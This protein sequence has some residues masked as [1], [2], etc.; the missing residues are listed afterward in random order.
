MLY[1]K[2]KNS[3]KKVKLSK[4]KKNIDEIKDEEDFN[5]LF[6]MD[7]DLYS[8]LD[9]YYDEILNKKVL[10]WATSEGEAWD[11]YYLLCDV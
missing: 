10:C 5:K 1:Y 4:L 7:V 3:F 6:S 9:P 8:F 2:R 11:L